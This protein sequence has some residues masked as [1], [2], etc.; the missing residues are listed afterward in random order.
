MESYTPQADGSTP[1]RLG[2]YELLGQLATG[3]MAE[4][5]LARLAGV[6]GFEKIVVVKRLLPE[7]VASKAYVAMLL[8]EGKLAGRLDHPNV[9]EVF[10]L[11]KDGGEYFLVMPYLDGVPATD[12][13]ARPRD[14]DRLAQLRVACGI[15]TQACAGLHHAHELRGP[16]GA[17]LGL[18][19]RDVSPSNLF[20]TTSGLVKVLDFGIAKVRGAAETEVG[21]IKGKTQYM[22]PEQLLGEPLDRRC[23]VFALGIVLYELATHQRLFKRASDYLTAR[24]ILEE[25]IPRADA[26]DPAVPAALADVIA[27]AL[28]RTPA[29]RYAT[30]RDLARAIEAAIDRV[31]TQD[32]IAAALAEWHG[33]E[34]SALRTRQAK[35]LGSHVQTVPLRGPAAGSAAPPT[36]ATR[37]WVL[38]LAALGVVGAAAGGW[39]A[40]HAHSGSP[41]IPPDAAPSISVQ[42]PVVASVPPDA[43]PPSPADA[44]PPDAP[45]AAPM[46]TP[47]A[48]H[49]EPGL[50]SIE[51]SPYATI[52]VDGHK[53]G[54]TPILKHALPAGHH[55]IRA[56]LQ[57]GRSKELGL[58]VPAGK[59]AAPINLSW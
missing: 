8:D 47:V 3:G 7:L 18:V 12:F 49:K 9:C 26:V 48:A 41:P 28:A 56:V 46:K 1:T 54:I 23:D 35:V 27:K 21:T 40:L 31:A 11:G 20:I 39:Y 30:A 45:V 43:P 57:D 2:R 42:A 5:H 44:A 24:A 14:P 4:I 53:L 38:P 17:P 34:L 32:Q 55:R 51:S 10:E 50:F 33:A 36:R 37:R 52:F 13:I 15:I 19:H 6:E 16:D 25:P 58:D 59:Q 29:D 22:A